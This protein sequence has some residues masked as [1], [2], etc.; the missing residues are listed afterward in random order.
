MQT[1]VIGGQELLPVEAANHMSSADG[2]AEQFLNEVDH[3]SRAAR[4]FR[5]IYASL[6]QHLGGEEQISEVRRHLARRASALTVWCEAEETKLVT[7]DKTGSPFD[8][9]V[10]A[11]AVNSLRRLLL[12]LGLNPAMRDI[13]P[14]LHKYLSLLDTD[15]VDTID[16]EPMP[17]EPA[18]PP[19]PPEPVRRDSRGRRLRGTPEQAKAAAHMREVAAW[20]KAEKEATR[21]AEFEATLATLKAARRGG[22]AQQAPQ[23]AKRGT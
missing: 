11:T 7:E 8:P 9:Q 5:D 4:R 10:Y 15:D 23:P 19:E 3:R 12:D 14:D 22:T 18:V 2:R 6:A 20:K 16:I 21:K 13:T 17:P 1:Q